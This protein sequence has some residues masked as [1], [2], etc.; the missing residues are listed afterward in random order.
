MSLRCPQLNKVP[1]VSEG[2]IETFC[3][4]CKLYFAGL[5]VNPARTCESDPCPF[6]DTM[7]FVVVK[8][9]PMADK[10]VMPTP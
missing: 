1:V 4:N 7:Q 2:Q 10:P 6:G 3:P 8:D 9:Q 5:C